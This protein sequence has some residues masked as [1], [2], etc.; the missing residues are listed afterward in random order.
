[1]KNKIG[2]IK[3]HT[4]NGNQIILNIFQ[5][6]ESYILKDRPT[7]PVEHIPALKSVETQ[8]GQPVNFE[9]DKMQAQIVTTGEL[10]QVDEV[11]Y[12]V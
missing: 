1:M 2:E 7:G 10:L 9:P 5:E 11:S 4:S 3:A 6:Y 8:D 12:I